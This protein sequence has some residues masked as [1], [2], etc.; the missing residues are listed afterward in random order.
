[1]VLWIKMHFPKN[2]QAV[3]P[4]LN[5]SVFGDRSFRQYLRWNEVLGLGQK[6]GWIG[7]F[8]KEEE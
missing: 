2:S 4:T 5:I 1:M 8:V 6:S 3:V 7:C